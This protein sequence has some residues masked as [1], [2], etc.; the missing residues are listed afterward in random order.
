MCHWITIWRKEGMGERSGRAAGGDTPAADTAVDLLHNSV[1]VRHRSDT[2]QSHI[3][4]TVN[5]VLRQALCTISLAL[6]L[7]KSKQGNLDHTLYAIARFGLVLEELNSGSSSKNL[8]IFKCSYSSVKDAD[9]IIIADSFPLLEELD[10][11]H[12]CFPERVDGKI[13]AVTDKGVTELSSRIKRL[14]RIN[15]TG[16]DCISDLS[17]ISSSTNCVDLMEIVVGYATGVTPDG[18]HIAGISSLLKQYQTLEPLALDGAE[19]LT[20]ESIEEIRHLNISGCTRVKF[21]GME[22]GLILKMEKLMAAWSGFDD[23]MLEMLGR[24]CPNLH[25]LDLEDCKSVT[26]QGVKGMVRKCRGLRCLNLSG[27][28]GVNFEVVDWIVSSCA[29]LRHLVSPSL[30]F[31]DE[32]QQ[33]DFASCGCLVDRSNE[34]G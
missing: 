34:Y 23:Q 31:P 20:D 30:S 1:G 24:I 29:S 26:T 19:F 7:P 10:I 2:T 22:D 33:E 8:K 32:K 5:P 6:A 14:R 12:S 13:I 25:H 21:S 15:L 16:N 9:L 3:D 28:D 11:S 18:L 4:S 27:C 17:V